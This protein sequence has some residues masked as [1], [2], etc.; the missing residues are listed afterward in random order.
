MPVNTSTYAVSGGRLSIDR[1]F[2]KRLEHFNIERLLLTKSSGGASSAAR[3]AE[4][5]FAVER[6][7]GA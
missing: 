6:R 3:P 7:R 5:I 2:F 4:F 1:A